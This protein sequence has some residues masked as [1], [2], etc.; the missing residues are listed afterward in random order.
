LEIPGEV[1][2]VAPEEAET[3]EL[4]SSPQFDDAMRDTF[5]VRASRFGVG[6]NTGPVPL[7]FGFLKGLCYESL[8]IDM[9]FQATLRVSDDRRLVRYTG[10]PRPLRGRAGSSGTVSLDPWV[11]SIDTPGTYRGTLVLA[12]DPNVGYEDPAIKRIWG[13]DLEFPI[14]FTASEP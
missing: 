8:P 10:V 6:S 14:V 7:Q 5:R 13:G 11:M 3:V 12:A 9:A 1:T 4:V 2:V